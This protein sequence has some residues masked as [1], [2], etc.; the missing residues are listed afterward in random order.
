LRVRNRFSEA[1]GDE[2][3]VFSVSHLMLEFVILV[4]GPVLSAVVFSGE[5]IVKCLNKSRRKKFALLHIENV[6]LV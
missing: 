4:V 6:G 2:F 3:F 5:L 1:A